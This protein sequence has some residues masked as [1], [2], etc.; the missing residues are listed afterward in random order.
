MKGNLHVGAYDDQCLVKWFVSR[1][2]VF[3]DYSDYWNYYATLYRDCDCWA[4]DSWKEAL[5]HPWCVPSRPS[6]FLR[7][8][9]LDLVDINFDTC[10]F[11]GFSSLNVD[12]FTL[13]LK[14]ICTI[15]LCD[16]VH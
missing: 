13:S 6:L 8:E 1:V 10:I 11:T 4:G 2:C 7:A 16:S 15:I 5:H 14:L 12:K 9:T 3:L